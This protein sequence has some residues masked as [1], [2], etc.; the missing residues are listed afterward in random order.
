MPLCPLCHDALDEISSP[1]WVFI[2]TDLQYFLDFEHKDYDRRREIYNST[3]VLPIRVS[4][5]AA[6]YLQHQ[7]ENGLVE[8]GAC[9]GLYACYMLRHYMAKMPGY[10]EIEVGKSPYTDEKPWHGDPNTALSKAFKAVGAKPTAFPPKVRGAL[11]EL[12]LLYGKDDS[13][14]REPADQPP[15]THPTGESPENRG[16][17]RPPTKRRHSDNAGD[18]SGQRTPSPTRRL[19]T[20]PGD[21]RNNRQNTSGMALK[22]KRDPEDEAEMDIRQRALEY[23]NTYRWRKRSRS[24][25]DSRWKW[26]PGATSQMAMKFYDAVYHLPHKPHNRGLMLDFKREREYGELERLHTLSS[27]YSLSPG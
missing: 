24:M 4:P 5:E 19:G 18:R 20:A 3:G 25:S 7:S 15:R 1:G 8:E 11:L 21:A 27:S 17:R 10:P 2:P 26:G 14:P 13:L 16:R 23:S 6:Q 9:G 22:R 12:S